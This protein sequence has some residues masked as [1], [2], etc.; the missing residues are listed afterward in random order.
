MTY[1]PGRGWSLTMGRI[2]RSCH[3]EGYAI[4]AGGGGEKGCV[5]FGVSL[6]GFPPYPP[7]PDDPNMPIRRVNFALYSVGKVRKIGLDQP[8]SSE[9][10]L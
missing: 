3:G 1:V 8:K 7:V 5:S 10:Y 2:A 6:G 4:L 9:G